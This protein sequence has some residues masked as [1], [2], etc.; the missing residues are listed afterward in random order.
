MKEYDVVIVGAGPAGIFA[1]L[2]LA[3]KDNI[4]VLVL[5]KG[6]DIE[7]RSARLEDKAEGY[8]EAVTSGWGGA[9]AFSDGKLTLSSEFGGWLGEYMSRDSLDKLIEYVD[10]VYLNYGAAEKEH[11]TDQAEIER[12]HH[13]AEL[14]GLIL[15]PAKIR[16]MGTEKARDIMKAM[17]ETL[18]QKIETRTGADVQ[19]IVVEN[20]LLKGVRLASGEMIWAK[21]VVVAPGRVGS[22]WLSS[23]ARRL[24][25]RLNMNAVDIGLRIETAA[26]VMEPIT[27][28][29][30]EPKL[31]YYSRSFDDKVRTF[32]VC[33][34]GEVAKESYGDVVTV[35]GQSYADR[36]TDNTNFALLVSTAF[37]DPFREP[38]A[39][40][41][42]I[43]R[44]A[45]LL[46]GGIIIQRLGDLKRGRRSTGARISQSLVT[47]TLKATPGD[48]SF[49]L[50][51]R[52]ICDILEMIE[53]LDKVAPGINSKDTLLYG[54]EVKFYS[55][56]LQLRPTFET[57]VKN[58][59]AIG[60]GAGI[61]RGLVQASVSGVA[62]ARAI[63]ASIK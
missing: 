3:K 58:L 43:A 22:D 8:Y 51:Y 55:S 25:L 56:R 44:L 36:K 26:S 14:A 60:D 30:Y 53:A 37:T 63:A 47:P 16:H 5:E 13:E 39:Y 6:Q 48:L 38:I 40:G 59:Y 15:I 12:L 54:V 10:S 24:N 57:E 9:G 46:G 45:N 1:A 11:G 23:E 29:L 50:P 18:D 17:K 34:N 2:E 62:A 49:V 41:K 28:Y 61:T 35:N 52:Y 21:A 42:H 20:G 4:K 33:P 32:C 27:K 31:V 7:A 19:E